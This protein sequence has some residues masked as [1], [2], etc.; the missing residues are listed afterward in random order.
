M[1]KKSFAGGLCIGIAALANMLSPHPVIGAIL[2][3][4]G[5]F[6]ILANNFKLC[7]GIFGDCKTM[8][9]W[10]EVIGVFIGNF[11]G[12]SVVGIAVL[13]SD[14]D[15]QKFVVYDANLWSVFIKS[16]LCGMMIHIGVKSYKNN[17][18]FVLALSIVVFVLCGMEHCV[19]NTFYLLFDNDKSFLAAYGINIFG[20]IIGAKVMNYFLS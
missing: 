9:D 5:L 17:R 11:F 1:N 10:Y 4:F 12:A 6:A 3:C 2:F 15:L 20:N 16:V 14:W 19:A 18:P 8:K 13:F 7:T